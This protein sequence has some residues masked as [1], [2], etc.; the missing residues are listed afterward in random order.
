MMQDDVI[1]YHDVMSSVL[2]SSL[3]TT[4]TSSS[5]PAQKYLNTRDQRA[6][7]PDDDD[8]HSAKPHPPSLMHPLR[9]LPLNPEE[10]ILYQW[11]LQRRLEEARKEAAMAGEEG[12]VFEQRR[13]NGHWRGEMGP[14]HTH[15]H[16][17]HSVTTAQNQ[18]CYSRA[19]IDSTAQARLTQPPHGISQQPNVCTCTQSLHQIGPPASHHPHLHSSHTHIPPH[20]HTLCDIVH[21][22][23]CSTAGESRLVEGMPGNGGPE[24]LGPSGLELQ[25]QSPGVKFTQVEPP[26]VQE[27]SPRL[28]LVQSPEAKFAQVEPPGVQGDT[29]VNENEMPPGGWCRTE[30]TTG[31]V[32]AKRIVQCVKKEGTRGKRDTEVARVSESTTQ[33]GREEL[34]LAGRGGGRQGRPPVQYPS[35]PVLVRHTSREP[36]HLQ[37]IPSDSESGDE[38]SQL[39]L[40]FSSEFERTLT[41]RSAA[42]QT[43]ADET[44]TP[45]IRPV[46]SQVLS[47]DCHVIFM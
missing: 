44:S 26:G 4:S 14:P 7:Q 25:G 43:R 1:I 37:T 40:T 41:P 10:D 34:P 20:K 28:E 6:P 5:L 3:L 21:C 33:H 36:L 22:P 2:S 8:P 39:S 15:M 24:C 11:R 9:E 23:Y 19:E 30:A 18:S 13:K 46:L 38:G 12:G 17:S 27:D 42:P 31:K 29:S 32:P 47:C 45:N 16:S 35:S